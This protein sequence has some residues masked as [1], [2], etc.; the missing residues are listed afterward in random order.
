MEATMNNLAALID[1][2]FAMWNETDVDRRRD[3]IAR[4]WTE[5]AAY[6]DPLVEGAG[7]A[8]IDAMVAGVQT[9]FPGHRFRRTSEIDAHH[10]C[11]RFAWELAPEGGAALVRGVDF[12][13]VIGDRLRSITGFLDQVPNQ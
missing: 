4:T 10:D 9:Q 1:R 7:Q 11:V 8:G 2:Y 5:D 13:V 6:I 3:L 12:G